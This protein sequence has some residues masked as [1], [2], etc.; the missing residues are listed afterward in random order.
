MLRSIMDQRPPS[1]AVVQSRGRTLVGLAL[2]STAAAC[3]AFMVYQARAMDQMADPLAHTPSMRLGLPVGTYDHAAVLVALLFLGMW[4]V[5]MA[6][7]MLP[8]VTPLVATYQQVYRERARVGRASV[9]ASILIA[10]YLVTWAAFGLAAYLIDR[11]AESWA[12]RAQKVRDVAPVVGGLLLLVAGL[13]Q[14]TPLKRACLRWCRTPAHFVLVDWREGRFGAFRMGLHNG[15]YCV[16]CCWAMMVALLVVGVMSLPWLALLAVVIFV[17]KN[18]RFAVPA[19]HALA[20][21]LIVS[22]VVLAVWPGALP[23]TMF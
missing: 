10:G 22:G 12:D 6:G 17:E 16:G 9:P 21:L 18:S 14:W 5:M 2:L 1:G 19:G 20:V 3:W 23:G 7:M 13:Y 8:A 15:L 4:T 11:G